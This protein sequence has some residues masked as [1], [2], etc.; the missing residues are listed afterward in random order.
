MDTIASI[1]GLIRL[2]VY[3]YHLGDQVG[4]DVPIYNCHPLHTVS[5]K[6][7]SW[8]RPEGGG[9]YSGMGGDRDR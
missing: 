9:I 8:R 7:K 4:M 5:R 2:P 3:S 6:W 1:C